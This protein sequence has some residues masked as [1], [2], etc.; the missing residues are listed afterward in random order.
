[1]TLPAGITITR[2]SNLGEVKALAAACDL[3]TDDIRDDGIFIEARE[4]GQLCGVAGVEPLGAVGLLRSVAVHPA[5]RRRGIA[6]AL[7]DEMMRQARTA[8]VRRLFLLTIDAERFFRG[9]GFA[10]IDR[11]SLPAEIRGTAQFREL[12]PQ[13]AIAMARDL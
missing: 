9:I 5:C 11:E 1:L 6:H 10:A 2:A 8:G 12:C 4:R 13:S 3:P 7:C